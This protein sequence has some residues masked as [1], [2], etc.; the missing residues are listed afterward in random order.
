[1]KRALQGKTVLVLTEKS[2]VRKDLGRALLALNA[3]LYYVRSTNE[4]WHRL[5]DAKEHFHCLLLDLSKND[6][7]VE[8]L[9]TALRAHYRYGEIPVVALAEDR[10]LSE[11]V[12]KLCSFVVFLPLSVGMLRESLL[13][14]LD[15]RS[16]QGYFQD[17][18]SAAGLEPNSKIQ[19]I[20]SGKGA[21]LL[22]SA[23]AVP[24]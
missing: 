21:D 4:L 9:L 12:Q 5:R 20:G 7:P 10:N 16:V 8:S 23:Q 17:T 22:L 1:M 6:L 14:C 19:A 2:A 11:T 18:S 15:R 24:C 3:D 13:W